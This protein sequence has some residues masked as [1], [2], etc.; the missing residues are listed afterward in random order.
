MH[1]VPIGGFHDDVFRVWRLGGAAQQDASGAAQVARKQ[2]TGGM[3]PFLEVQ[4]NTGR[5]QD[6]ARVDEGSV[7]AGRDLKHFYVGCGSSE[8]IEAVQCVE[9]GIERL[10]I[11][12]ASTVMPHLACAIARVFL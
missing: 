4:K 1:S 10:V 11:V 6:V 8:I 3:A 7:H 9:G 2:H 5:A 12:V